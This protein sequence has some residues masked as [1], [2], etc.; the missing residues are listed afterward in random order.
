MLAL[1]YALLSISENVGNVTVSGSALSGTDNAWC[2]VRP[3]PVIDIEDYSALEWDLLTSTILAAPYEAITY[4]AS[5]FD[6]ALA[7]KSDIPGRTLT[8]L[9]R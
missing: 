7:S 3:C 2:T 9:G 4:P 5:G 1:S 6:R 8:C